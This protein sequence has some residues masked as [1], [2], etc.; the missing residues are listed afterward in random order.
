M[1]NKKAIG[2][3][4]KERYRKKMEIKKMGYENG[5]KRDMNYQ[6]TRQVVKNKN[7]KS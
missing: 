5:I 3:S 1:T 7:I 2:K 4:C 6:S